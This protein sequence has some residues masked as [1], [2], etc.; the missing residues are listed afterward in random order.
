MDV[1]EH[2]AKKSVW[3]D[4]PQ[5]VDQIWAEAYVYW[6]LGEEL[7]LPKE[8]EALAETQQENHRE[9]SEKEGQII[10][11]LAKPVLPNWDQMDLC[12][13]RQFWQG[14]LQYDRSTELVP[15]EK[16]CAL[17][18]WA[19]CFN[20]DPKYI[21]RMDSFEINSIMSG[22]KGWKRNKDKRRYGRY[23]PRRGFDRCT[24]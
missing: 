10:D 20:S 15:R 21:K 5:E 22:L 4:L 24:T 8:I 7:Y 6:M 23:G 2:P 19:E 11:F 3:K 14:S 1:G 17:E 16:V 13:R 12:R 9:A 18:I